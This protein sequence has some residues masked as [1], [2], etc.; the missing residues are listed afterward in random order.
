MAIPFWKS[1]LKIWFV[2]I[3][4]MEGWSVWVFLQVDNAARYGTV[5]VG[6]KQ[7]DRLFQRKRAAKLVDLSTRAFMFSIARCLKIFRKVQRVWKE[8]FFHGSFIFGV[9]AQEQRGMFIDIGTPGDYRVLNSFAPSV[10]DSL[11][12]TRVFGAGSANAK[13]RRFEGIGFAA[14]SKH[15]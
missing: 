11:P 14:R 2:F 4:D 3:A 12:E 10:R 13:T 1:I 8:T 15:R 5:R 9:Y 6:S 7:S